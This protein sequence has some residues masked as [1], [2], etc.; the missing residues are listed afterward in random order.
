MD[1]P[2]R[3]SRPTPGQLALA[4]RLARGD[5]ALG[6]GI[7]TL[8]ARLYLDEDR[9][10]QEQERLFGRLPLLLGPSAM[11]PQPN[12]AIAHDDYGVP[13]IVSRDG[14][15]R[16]H[17]LANVCRHR[18]TRL[19]ESGDV[20]PANRIVCP[21]HAW[22]YRSDGALAGVPRAECFPGLEKSD[23]GLR[24]FAAFESGGLIWFRRSLEGNFVAVEQLVDDMD[25][26]GLAALHLYRRNT[27]DVAANWKLVIDAFLESYHVARLHAATIGPFFADGITAADTIGLHQRAVVGRADYLANID[28]S[29]WGELRRAVTY[30]YHLFPNTVVVVS[31]D[32][33]NLLICYPQSAGRTLVEDIMLIPEAPTSADAERHWQKS[34]DLLD[35]GT[36]GGEDFR[37]AAL[38]HQGLASGLVPEITIG[39]LEHGIAEFHA[40]VDAALA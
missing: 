33:I 27:H 14:E 25:A 36:F 6:A 35:A 32:Y 12:Q 28:R 19:I 10:A 23:F 11:L 22:A 24:E 1:V 30:T 9:F 5:A 31:P 4:E 7:K 40:K 37:A 21:Y 8:P 26:F 39:S 15:G 18:G 34:W 20:V 13:L 17:V 38:C 29:D 3:S 2:V 16:A